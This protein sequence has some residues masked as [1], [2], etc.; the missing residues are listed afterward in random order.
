MIISFF[1]FKSLNYMNWSSNIKT[2]L[3][4][5]NKLN[6]VKIVLYTAGIVC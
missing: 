4:S 3:D 1:S 2:I 6:L 5:C